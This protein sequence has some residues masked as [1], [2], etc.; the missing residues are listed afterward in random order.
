[1]KGTLTQDGQASAAT[2]EG[3]EAAVAGGAFLLAR[4]RH[5]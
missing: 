3:I 4:P 5:P 2:P 1:M